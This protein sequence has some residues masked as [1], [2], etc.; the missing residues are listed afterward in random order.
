MENACTVLE[1]NANA[2]IQQEAAP[3]RQ[4]LEAVNQMFNQPQHL[5]RLPGATGDNFEG[6]RWSYNPEAKPYMDLRDQIG[7]ELSRLHSLGIV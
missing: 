6:Y 2:S 1:G 4:L 3:G 5:Q 7:E